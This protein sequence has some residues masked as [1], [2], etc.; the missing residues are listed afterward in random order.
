[1]SNS[2]LYGGGTGLFFGVFT[3]A[4]MTGLV[5]DLSG[6]VRD[7]RFSTNEHGFATLTAY[8]PL[9]L[10]DSFYLYDRPGLP[11]VLVSDDGVTVWEGRLEDVAI[12]NGG[13]RLGAYGYWRALSDAPYT[14]M[15]TDARTS[16]WRAITTQDI[17]GAP[18]ERYQI[19]ANANRLWIS[20]NKSASYATSTD[21]GGIMYAVPHLSA[22]DITRIKLDYTYNLPTNWV[23]RIAVYNDTFGSGI[24]SSITTV[25]GSAASSATWD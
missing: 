10:T 2:L 11:H 25:G 1:M 13:V 14:A 15:W 6:R 4:A 8:C 12:V 22:R 23:F 16:S 19:N 21:V 9:S 18:A 24:T 5:A 17:L 20:L 3:D 7:V